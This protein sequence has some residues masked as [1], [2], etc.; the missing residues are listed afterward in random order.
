MVWQKVFSAA[1]FILVFIIPGKYLCQLNQKILA[2]TGY[3][4]QF[5]IK[6]SGLIVTGSFTNVIGQVVYSENNELKNIQHKATV[7][8]IKT[9]IKR[10]D[11][12]LASSD[13]FDSSKFPDINFSLLRISSRDKSGNY[14][15]DIKL[16]IR[17]IEKNYA[18]IIREVKT[19]NTIRLSSTFKLN[20]RD[21]GV[22][23][24]SFA[25]ADEVDILLVVTGKL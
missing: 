15:A 5:S 2:V 7:E 22:G 11:K 18:I 9:G 14:N 17:N 24:K 4:A 23:G 10:R 12:H 16:T 20:R 6:H 8:T 1:L 13:Y 19:E 21:F 25:M 3:T